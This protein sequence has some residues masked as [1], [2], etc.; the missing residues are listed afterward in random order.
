MQ[1]LEI[2]DHFKKRFNEQLNPALF[3]VKYCQSETK[4]V[5]ELDG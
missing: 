5:I 4:D 2:Y 3:S 1:K